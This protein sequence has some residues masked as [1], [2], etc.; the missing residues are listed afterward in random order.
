MKQKKSYKN[1]LSAEKRMTNKKFPYANT[2]IT[3]MVFIM[4]ICD[5]SLPFIDHIQQCQTN[6]LQQ[7][8]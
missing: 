3:I 7:C 8:V 2:Q 4:V 1:Y 6:I 5:I